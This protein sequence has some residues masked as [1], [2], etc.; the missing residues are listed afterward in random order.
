MNILLRILAVF[1]L[2][3]SLAYGSYAVGRYVLSEKLFGNTLAAQ[4]KIGAVSKPRIT[5][6]KNLGANNAQSPIEVQVLP[7]SQADNGPDVA[8]LEDLKSSP[9]TAGSLPAS[10]PKIVNA[11]TLGKSNS[12]LKLRD[13]SGNA[14][15][16]ENG[17]Q[18]DNGD[19]SRASRRS[20]RNR[21]RDEERPRRRR[22]KRRS[23]T[24]TV[25][26]ES[27]TRSSSASDSTLSPS[28]RS[29][30]E[31]S[32]PARRSSSS[33]NDAPARSQSGS[34]DSSPF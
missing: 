14:I 4:P 5:T 26:A 23:S 3:G 25:V 13:N 22:R 12:R 15:Y 20:R 8:S 7:A 28:R 21:N 29:S 17:V 6:R 27:S 34:S 24:A 18:S 16:G 2:L 9:K 31:D 10:K 11:N 33:S 1:A 19:D 32:R 30:S